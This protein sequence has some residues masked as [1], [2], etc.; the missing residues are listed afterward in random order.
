MPRFERGVDPNAVL[1]GS[2][3]AAE[4]L[5]LVADAHVMPEPIDHYPVP[6]T[7]AR[8]TV[9]VPRVEALLG[10]ALGTQRVK[11]SLAPLEIEIEEVGAGG[12][13]EFVA[14]PPT[15]RPDLEREIDIVEEVARRVGFN[16]I[17]RTLPDTTGASGGLTVRQR[18]RRLIE[19]VLVGAGAAEAMTV[20]L[21]AVADLERFGLSTDRTV[22]VTNALRADEPILRPAI[23]PGLLKSAAH[24][25]SQGL[26]DLELFELGHVFAS[27]QPGELLPDER[28]H[29][30]VLLTGTVSRGPIEPDRSVDVY[31]IVDLADAVVEAMELADVRLVA[32]AAPG[33]DAARSA[34]ITVD[35]EVIGHVGAIATPVLDAFGVP[36]VGVA[37]ELDIDGL[38]RGG[39][40]DRTFRA[41]SRFPGSTIDLA[42]VLPDSVAA[43]DVERTLRDATGEMVELVRCFD[44]FR[45][46]AL[47]PGRR[48]LTFALRF[49]APDRTL[50]DAE[51]AGLR[52][53]GID[54]VIATHGAELRG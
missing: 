18:E 26:A 29:L 5:R 53:A 12:G 44:E 48:S 20:P 1:T 49:R 25:A 21:I 23:L 17:P 15:F 6:I 42:F 24:N 3:R 36:G 9:R 33:F 27:P 45:S 43:A 37:L 31:D 11:D 47:G 14:I 34:D 28:D 52:Q 40:R 50:K 13:D 41:L 32:A 16:D 10:V 30:A 7:P 8:I 4:L 39:R 22:E 46:D 2:D 54:A 38:M 35:G 51:I 19:D